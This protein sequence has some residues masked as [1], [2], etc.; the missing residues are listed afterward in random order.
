MKKPPKLKSII[1]NDTGVF[2][3]IWIP[4]V[5]A[6]VAAGAFI[7][8]ESN[9]D[10]YTALEI[11]TFSPLIFISLS[12]CLW[13]FILWWWYS[14]YSTFKNGIEL[15]ANNTQKIIKRAFDLGIVYNFNFQGKEFEHTASFVPNTATKK[16]ADTKSLIIV[17]NPKNNLSFI[18]SAYV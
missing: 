16:I 4:I 2:M 6:F 8:F 9:R 3:C 13:P 17:F 15:N 14:I 7:Y 5:F 10:N 1:R 11:I 18:K 12:V